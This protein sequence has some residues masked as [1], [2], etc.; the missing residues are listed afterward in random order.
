MAKQSEMSRSAFAA[1]FANLTDYTPAQYVTLWRMHTAGQLLKEGKHKVPAIAEM[2]GYES[3]A[4][5]GTAF[6]RVYVCENQNQQ[7]PIGIW[8]QLCKAI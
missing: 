2:V 3:E 6:K 5:F 4:L 8:S 1:K 7:N